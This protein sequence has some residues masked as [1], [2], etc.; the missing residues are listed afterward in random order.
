MSRLYKRGNVYWFDFRINGTRYRKSTGETK[1][2]AAEDVLH[3]EKEKA[4]KGECSGT[5]KIKDCKVAVLADEYSKWVSTQKSYITSKRFF[6]K[7]IKEVFGNI[8]V[9]DL[10]T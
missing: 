4:K 9:S 8:N 2:R 5:L 1:R 6:I 3:D 7:Q 10:D